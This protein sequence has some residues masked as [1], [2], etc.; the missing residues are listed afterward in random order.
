MCII[1]PCWIIFKKIWTLFSLLPSSSSVFIGLSNL[2]PKQHRY[3][4]IFKCMLHFL[5]HSLLP[6]SLDLSLFYLLSL[7]LSL[8]LFVFGFH[9]FICTIPS[10][11][12]SPDLHTYPAQLI[13]VLFNVPTMLGL[14]YN[15]STFLLL[16]ISYSPLLF[17]FRKIFSSLTF[18]QT[19]LAFFV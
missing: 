8:G 15:S 12:Y 19:F 14:L 9:V 17:L 13:L 16:H 4:S 2:F 5:L 10:D 18:S 6:I 11:S 1:G 7:S 3:S